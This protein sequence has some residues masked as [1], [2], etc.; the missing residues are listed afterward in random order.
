[1]ESPKKSGQVLM[2]SLDHFMYSYIA[3]NAFYGSKA[4]DALSCFNEAVFSL[5]M[6]GL[7]HEVNPPCQIHLAKLCKD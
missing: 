2:I 4:I 1:M 3:K 5:V 7:K 6:F